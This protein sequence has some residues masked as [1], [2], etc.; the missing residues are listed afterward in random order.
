MVTPQ[1]SVST[2]YF[3]PA[4]ELEYTIGIDDK[5]VTL[6]PDTTPNIILDDKDDKDFQASRKNDLDDN[7][8]NNNNAVIN[9]KDTSK[10]DNE[11]GHGITP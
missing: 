8:N 5:E 4:T 1:S 10:S 2:E 9:N 7:N 6:P 3:Q 11:L